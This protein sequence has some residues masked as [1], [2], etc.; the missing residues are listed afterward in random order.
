MDVPEEMFDVV[1]DHHQEV[2]TSPT[3]D[4]V[5]DVVM[6][7][8]PGETD[9]HDK[10]DNEDEPV[11]R[12]L[13]QRH[14]YDPYS[15]DVRFGGSV[16]VATANADPLSYQQAIHSLDSFRWIEA[17]QKELNSL[18]SNNTWELVDTPTDRKLI[19]SKWV[20]KKKYLPSGLIDKYKARLVA[21]GFTQK[22]GIDFEETFSPTLRYESLRLLL[23]LATIYRL[24]LWLLDVIT[25]YLNGD[26][27]KVIYMS[28]PEG[29]P[30]TDQNKGKCL[31]I[32]KG[33]YGL[34]QSGRIWAEKFRKCLCDFGFTAIQADQCI[35]I[36]HFGKEVCLVALYVDD[37]IIATK[38]TKAYNKVKEHLTSAF[39]ITDGGPL[40]AIL[41]IRVSQ[42]EDIIAMDQA[43]YVA[44]LLDKYGMTN[45]NGVSTP[46]DGYEGIQAAR[47]DEERA[48]QHEYQRLV[49]ELMFLQVATRPDLAFAISKLSQFC[50]DPVVRHRNALFRV[51]KYLKNAPNLAICFRRDGGQPK[52]FADAAFADNKE[53]RRS[54]YGFIMTNA[55]A[56]CVW[57]SRKQRSVATSTVE[58]EYMAL[59]EGC[60]ASIW[61]TRWMNESG[62]DQSN[63]PIILN[64]DNSGS[65]SLSKN[66]GNHS[67]T[68]H[69]EV[70]YHFI[71]EKVMEGLIQVEHVSTRDQLAD[72]MTKP[73]TKQPF[74]SNRLKLGLQR[75][76]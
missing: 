61:A 74:E 1:S 11:G 7:D 43:N 18:S 12:S 71:R 76:E 65:I 13:R 33:L 39:K 3:A 31:R 52:Y 34:K 68:K 9:D 62:L 15:F 14:H 56:A 10:D 49:G 8:A 28:I 42:N 67:R 55:G 5:Q 58:A 40:K 64:G 21:R 63:G 50:N 35:F 38:S 66:P 46:I 54:S 22:Q 57:Y 24:R 32:L 45:C 48:N 72:I 29:I 25:A 44:N 47:R 70:A 26:L 41:G 37:I 53:D 60:K 51:L 27:D 69:I 36:R 2:N 30:A 6:D 16:L 75:V 73:L 23:S 20:F 17:I 59:S 4:G 19:S